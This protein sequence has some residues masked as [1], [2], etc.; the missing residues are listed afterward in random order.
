MAMEVTRVIEEAHE[1]EIVSL[2]YNRARKEIY[3][4]ADG[5]KVIKVWDSRN[6]QLLRTQQGHKGMVT[7]LQFSNSVRL[8]FSGSIDNTVGIWTEK[9]V[10][11][12]MTSVAGPV[13]SLAWDE[14]RRYLIVGGHAV[15]NIFKVDMAE[16]RKLSQQQRSVASGLKDSGVGSG[17]I[18]Q[19]LRRMYPPM[20]GPDLCHWDVVKCIVVTETGKIMSGGFD[21]AICIYE[22]DK[23][24]K[25]KEAFQRIRKCHTAAIV[26]M[27]YDHQNNCILSGSIDGSMKVWSMEGRLLDKFT[28]INDQPVCVA[29]V[30]PTNMYWASGRFG[31][32]VAYDPRAPSNVTEYVRDSNSLDRFRVTTLF[33]PLH[34]DLLLGAT[35][36]RQLVVWQ[37]NKQAAYRQVQCDLHLTDSVMFKKHEDW[38][39]VLVVV[40]LNSRPALGGESAAGD[41]R[42][43]RQRFTEADGIERATTAGA[44]S[45]RQQLSTARSAQGVEIDSDDDSGPHSGTGAAEALGKCV[46]VWHADVTPLMIMSVINGYSDSG[47]TSNEVEDARPPAQEEIFS[48]GADGKVLRWQLDAEEN[49]DIYVCV[50]EIPLHNKNILA[51]AYS[52]EL[53]CLITGG[54]DSTI[55]VK[56]LNQA[57]PTFNDMPLPTSFVD[58]ELR[59]TGLALLKHNVLA[60]ISADRC[61]RTWD[62]TTMK[63]LGCVQAAHDTPLQC[64]EYCQESNEIATCGMGNKVKIWDAQRP[65]ALR[66][67]LVLNHADNGAHDSDDE[68]AGR[69]PKS[70]MTWLT[71]SDM[72][73][74]AQATNPLVDST[75]KAAMRDTP[76]VT[77]VRWVASRGVWVTAADD[78]MIRLWSPA[79]VKLSQWSQNG[80]SVQCLYV[81]HVNNLLV[82]A[83]QDK[84]CCVYDLDDPI[85]RAT[86]KG[87][88]D[89]VKGIGYLAAAKCYVTASWDKS[90]RLWY[91]PTHQGSSSQ[92]PA[93][94]AT[95]PSGPGA[96]AL[97]E[98][99]EDEEHFVSNYEKAHPLEV[100]RALTEANQWQL[101]KAIG[102]LEEDKAGGKKGRTRHLKAR[103][104]AAHPQCCPPPCS[105]HH[106]HSDPGKAALCWNTP[107]GM[108]GPLLQHIHTK[109]I[110]TKAMHMKAMHMK[111]M[112]MKA[113]HM[114]AM[115]RNAMHRDALHMEAMLTHVM[116]IIHV[117][118]KRIHLAAQVDETYGAADE[119]E[120]PGT[121][122]SKLNDL[123]KEL[124]HEINAMARQRKL[125]EQQA[126]MQ[127]T[128]SVTGSAQVTSR[129]SVAATKKR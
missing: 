27:A 32:L 52:P 79:G 108:C 69:G 5:D 104:S 95:G 109:A 117:H 30:P 37:H 89:V 2:T 23:L 121:L 14:R 17:D 115:H 128:A 56:Y 126:A 96:V 1:G 67:K 103:D 58:H 73:G 50:E 110:H 25:P 124:L 76:E 16:A 64:I 83:M 22:F 48:G 62:L 72:P 107:R 51:I 18:P 12:Q 92:Q 49:C 116:H 4:S 118:M 74:L 33:A 112:H 11:L 10:S 98:D 90:L 26:S 101:L 24:D 59:V 8:L 65:A 31:R 99:D 3:S 46:S 111:A 100:P 120:L 41:R 78:D 102:V 60:S 42:T 86:Y 39:E 127:E 88:T 77:Q 47:L 106:R 54:E 53:G 44:T 13:F 28:S 29:Y 6:G 36:K 38:V 70:N 85:P 34:T 35:A 9:G 21:K 93:P 122:G 40:P 71:R 57:V 75:I 105:L 7:C 123:G 82:V 97:V 66:L 91:A 113:M 80:G 94:G 81:D 125:L 119:P 87:H 63:P 84:D 55:Q 114:K 43:S 68:G 61:L 19:I 45:F 15:I 20:K 129:R